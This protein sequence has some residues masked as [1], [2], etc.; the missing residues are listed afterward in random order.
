MRTPFPKYLLLPLLIASCAAPSTPVAPVDFT[1]KWTGAS[2][3]P[4]MYMYSVTLDLKQTQGNVTGTIAVNNGGVNS[5][6]GSGTIK[7]TGTGDQ[8][9]LN[10]VF[11]TV[12][13]G[14]AANCSAVLTG[15][16][17]ARN[18]TLQLNVKFGSNCGEWAQRT[19]PAVFLVR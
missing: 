6:G 18:D 13:Y 8:V 4:G 7:G 5:P 16:N 15:F 12:T 19:W 9:S 2:I 17:E 10:A 3:E 1:G 11:D 14:M